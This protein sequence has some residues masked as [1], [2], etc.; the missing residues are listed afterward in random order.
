MYG[1][2][3]IE[4]VG[5]AENDSSLVIFLLD[6]TENELAEVDVLMF[7]FCDWTKL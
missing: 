1:A 4:K 5:N 6:T 2:T 7:F 3:Y